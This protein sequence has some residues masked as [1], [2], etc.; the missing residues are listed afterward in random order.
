M[1]ASTGFILGIVVY[2]GID[3]RMAMN[4]SSPRMKTG[5]LDLEVNWLTKVLFVLM[6]L[7]SLVIVALDGF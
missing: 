3:T 4:T 2:T 5:K 7:I 6:C 1:L